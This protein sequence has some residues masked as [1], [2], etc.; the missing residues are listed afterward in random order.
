MTEIRKS[1]DN[2]IE[3]GAT[4]PS[5][6]SY[7]TVLAIGPE[8]Q[9]AIRHM[10]P[11]QLEEIGDVP[12]AARSGVPF[13]DPR[14]VEAGWVMYEDMCKGRVVGIEADELAWQRWQNLVKCKAQGQP[15]PAGKLGEDFWHA[16]VRRRSRE[17]RIPRLSAAQL[18]ELFPG[19]TIEDDEEEAP[20]ASDPGPDDPPP[21]KKGKG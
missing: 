17:G 1:Y 6:Y 21:T 10:L 5:P 15:I 13:L 18:R 2:Y 8:G 12:I 14:Y 11:G 9:L 19:A 3:L 4:P 20:A 16:E 7:P